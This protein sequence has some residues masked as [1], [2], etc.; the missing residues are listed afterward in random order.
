MLFLSL[1][2]LTWIFLFHKENSQNSVKVLNLPSTVPLSVHLNAIIMSAWVVKKMHLSQVT[3]L[4]ASP[5]NDGV[6]IGSG[7][8]ISRFVE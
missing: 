5:S 6:G 8:E 1:K 3:M 2:S 7:E 4:V